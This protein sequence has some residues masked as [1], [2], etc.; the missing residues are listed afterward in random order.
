MKRYLIAALLLLGG[1]TDST[2]LGELRHRLFQE[3]MAFAGANVDAGVINECSNQSSYMANH[4][5][6]TRGEK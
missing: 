5:H 1:C 4:I 6:T 2:G 3:C